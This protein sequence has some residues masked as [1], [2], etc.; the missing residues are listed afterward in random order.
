[1]GISTK[2]LLCYKKNLFSGTAAS[3]WTQQGFTDEF[4]NSSGVYW[5]IYDLCDELDGDI[6]IDNTN[7]K[8]LA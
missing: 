3:V 1:M 6:K 2:M 5:F 8:L 4:E 7:I